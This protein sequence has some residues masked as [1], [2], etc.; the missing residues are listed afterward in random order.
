MKKILYYLCAVMLLTCVE[1]QAELP[2]LR[3]NKEGKFK[4]VQF[5]D[6]HYRPDGKPECVK[7]L[8][9]VKTVLGLEN[10]DLIVFT[11]D[12]VT[13]RPVKKAWA[14]IFAVCAE[15][16]IPFAVT[17]GNHD[18]EHGT[19][20]EGLC[21]IVSSHPLSLMP[22]NLYEVGSSRC[23][24]VNVLSSKGDKPINA[25]FMMDSNA[26]SP[27]KSI[28]GYG[29][30][31]NDQIQWYR[32]TSAAI[33]QANNRKPLPALGFFH[34]PLPEYTPA[35]DSNDPTPIGVRGEDECSPKV[36]SGMFVAMLESQNMMGTFV[37]HDHVNDYIA[38][39]NGIAL[40]YGRG[41]GGKTTY[42]EQIPGGRVILLTENKRSFETYIRNC[43]GE[44]EYKASYPP[45]RTL[46]N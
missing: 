5:T 7:V 45:K 3:F 4:I 29:W 20:R 43:E 13:G 39:F 2:V 35:F 15:F 37:G 8:E 33:R 36:N 12:V 11:G 30:F 25:L 21:E 28:E 46:K 38:V 40:C 24:V 27:I 26:Y 23:Y 14:D 10:P 32:Q 9:T 34:I 1:V 44:I 18:D 6:L 31:T 22:A 16:N 17:F 19:T 41:T 42:G